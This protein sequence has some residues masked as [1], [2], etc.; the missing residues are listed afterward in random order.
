[1][2]PGR[3]VKDAHIFGMQKQID[4]IHFFFFFFSLGRH[5]DTMASSM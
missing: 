1:M 3:R 2:G 5:V 4:A